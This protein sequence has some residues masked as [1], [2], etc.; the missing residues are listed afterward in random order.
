MFKF[1]FSVIRL[2]RT[3]NKITKLNKTKQK[4]TE[5]IN[6]SDEVALIREILLDSIESDTL[7]NSLQPEKNVMKNT[8]ES[9]QPKNVVKNDSD[10][11]SVESV[12]I[13][14]KNQLV[15]DFVVTKIGSD[16]IFVTGE[17]AKM[18][19]IGVDDTE[20]FHSGQKVRIKPL[21]EETIEITF[22]ES[23]EKIVC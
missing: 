4:L 19:N 11:V 2:K 10:S 13:K 8:K 1:I 23:G 3:N 20:K 5:T 18:I 12:E 7:I 22:N 6:Q 16:S 15:A 17:N 9:L 14:P 21:D